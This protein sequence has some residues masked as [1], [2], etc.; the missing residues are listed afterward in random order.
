MSLLSLGYKNTMKARKDVRS[1]EHI[2][3]VKAFYKKRRYILV[4]RSNDW[5]EC[6]LKQTLLREQVILITVGRPASMVASCRGS[7]ASG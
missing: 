1:I 4:D 7:A 5:K 2:C 6:V 3:A